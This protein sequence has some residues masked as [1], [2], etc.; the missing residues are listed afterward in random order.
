MKKFIAIILTLAC[1]A[2]LA[3]PA[4]AAGELNGTTT[5]GNHDVTVDI[6]TAAETVY[7]LDVNWGTLDFTYD[8]E[9]DANWNAVEHTYETGAAGK[10]GTWSNNGE[11]TITVTNRSN[12]AVN[13]SASFDASN[14][15]VETALNG[16]TATLTDAVDIASAVGTVKG[17]APSGSITCTVAGVPLA[18]DFTVGVITLKF[19]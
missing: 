7:E 11:A 12:A 2:V 5:S 6:T 14:V 13:V 15:V 9:E 18:D 1:A 8:F 17:S 16:V 4:F 10:V 3:I 19:N